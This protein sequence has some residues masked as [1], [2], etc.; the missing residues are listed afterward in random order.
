MEN[1]NSPYNETLP[2]K[3]LTTTAGSLSIFG[4][5]VIFLT[6][7]IW[8]DLRTASRKILV[9]ISIGDFLTALVNISGLWLSATLYNKVTDS[10]H[11]HGMYIDLC[12]AEGFV[13]IAAIISSFFWTFYLSVYLYLAVCKG[14]ESSTERIVLRV[15]HVTAW[16]IP[17]VI[18]CLAL[19]L[20]NVGPLVYPNKVSDGWCWV[21]TG[22]KNPNP[23]EIAWMFIAGKG[24]EILAY[25][26][27]TAFYIR[28]KV[29]LRQQVYSCQG[30][31]FLTMGSIEAARKADRKFTFIPVI[32]ILLRMWGTIRF[33]LYISGQGH[34]EYEWLRILHGI[35]DSSQGFA[36][37]VIFCVFTEKMGSHFK[38]WFS[39]IFPCCSKPMESSAHVGYESTNI[40]TDHSYE[41]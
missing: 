14:L 9:Y 2:N 31:P 40:L 37:F 39:K 22:S 17:L 38:Y 20:N 41:T 18:A 1:S 21:K 35:G 12:T 16:G 30:A 25:I 19:A 28:V 6:F 29:H 15:F 24:W 8:K 36:N 34:P 23:N 10:K 13:N 33:F 11:D 32:F 3:I 26:G 27:I 4:T 7:Y 5:L